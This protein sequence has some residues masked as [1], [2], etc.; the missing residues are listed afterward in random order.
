MFIKQKINYMHDNPCSDKWNLCNSPIDYV[1]SSSR[2]Y[3]AGED[4]FYN[5]TDV[6]DNWSNVIA[7][8]LLKQRNVPVG[9]A[10]KEDV[11]EN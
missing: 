11:A 2:Y 8:S 3:L 6:E 10:L 5:V 9:D 7:V 1:H 4:G